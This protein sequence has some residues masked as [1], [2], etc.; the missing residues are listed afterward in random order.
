MQTWHTTVVD[1]AHPISKAVNPWT[2]DDGKTFHS[3]IVRGKNAL[4][5]VTVLC[6]YT[7]VAK[8]NSQ[9]GNHV[10]QIGM[11]KCGQLGQRVRP[12][13]TKGPGDEVGNLIQSPAVCST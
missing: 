3:R 2:C 4:C 10:Y 8:I 6:Q 5:L 12:N 11:V 13:M 9:W 7:A 1:Y